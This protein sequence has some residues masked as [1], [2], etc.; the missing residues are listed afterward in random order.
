MAITVDEQTN[1]I[2]VTDVGE[3]VDACDRIGRKIDRETGEI[4]EGPIRELANG[5]DPYEPYPVPSMERFAAEG[6]AD[7]MRAEDI[8]EVA[9][10]LIAQYGERFAALGELDIIYLWRRK[11][12]NSNGKDTLGKTMALSGLSKHLA[13]G[14]DAAI[15]LAADHVRTRGFPRWKVEALVYHELAHLGVDWETGK[16]TIRGHDFDGFRSELELFG[17]WSNDL[18][19]LQETVKQLNMFPDHGGK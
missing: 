4:L 6:K 9:E 15:W 10:A 11:G 3:F 1:T 14:A 5:G 7:Y 17:Y 2:T 12:G 18:D 19:G 8:Q 16:A 13:E